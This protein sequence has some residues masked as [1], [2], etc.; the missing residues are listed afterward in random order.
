MEAEAQ[1]RS[2]A[3]R[4]LAST[5]IMVLANSAYVVAG[6]V[7]DGA[8]V[9]AASP[10]EFLTLTLPPLSECLNETVFLVSPDC[11]SRL[12]P[13]LWKGRAAGVAALSDGLKML[14]LRM[15]AGIPHRP[16]FEPLLRFL[17]QTSDTAE[18]PRN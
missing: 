5:L 9:V 4:D 15:P 12:Q 13:E 17:S 7:G 16:F 11:F 10:G 18:P 14:A 6:Q 1:R 8:V 2:L 3:L